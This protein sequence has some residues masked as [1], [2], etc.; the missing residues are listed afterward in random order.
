MTIKL[1]IRIIH[2]LASRVII[3]AMCQIRGVEGSYRNS[4]LYVS[5]LAIDAEAIMVVEQA[6]SSCHAHPSLP[7]PYLQLTSGKRFKL[8]PCFL[9]KPWSLANFLYAYA[10]VC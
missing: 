4:Y 9:K 2:P 7:L 1:P 10:R 8:F 6:R 5:M 3:E